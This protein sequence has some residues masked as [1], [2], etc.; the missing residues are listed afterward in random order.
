[1]P[2][3]YRYFEQPETCY[4][5]GFITNNRILEKAAP[6]LEKAQ[7]QYQEKGGKQHPFTSFSYQAKSWTYPRRITASRVG[8]ENGPQTQKN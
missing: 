8:T 6:L 5:I 1:M 4:V 2:A 7:R 3:L